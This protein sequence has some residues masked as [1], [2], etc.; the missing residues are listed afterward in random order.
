[1]ANKLSPFQS[2]LAGR[3]ARQADDYSTSRNMLASMEVA[4]APAEQERRNALANVQLNTA[5]LNNQGAQQSLD[6]DKA[7][8]AYAQ[9]RQARDSGNTKE[10]IVKQ[11]PE[12]ANQ[13]AR[14]NVDLNSMDESQVDDLVDQLSRK[15]GGEAGI[16]PPEAIT[17][18]NIGGANVLTQGGKYLNSF[19]NKA[20]S[21][22]GFTLPPGA[23]RFDANGKL[24]A[25]APDR[26]Q[27]SAAEFTTMTPEE[28]RAAGLPA[29]TSAQKN[30][31][32]GQVNVISK[33]E[34][35]AAE[36]K[37]QREIKAKIPR[38]KAADR[39]LA[40]VEQAVESIAKNKM[41]DGGEID[42]YAIDRTAEGRELIAASAQLLPELTA[43]T[44]VPGIGSQSDLE[45]RLANLQFPSSEFPPEV[46]RKNAAEL[47][48][49][50]SD[51]KDAYS[52]G[53]NEVTKEAPVSSP[54]ASSGP[55]RVRSIQEAQS[56]PPGTE[57]ITPDGRHKVR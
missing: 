29:G 33:P 48:A 26:P 45:T 1:M 5:Q 23:Q 35:N 43:L 50:I 3:E 24:I 56:L 27:K 47:R 18:Q 11:I 51:L 19:S 16:L 55:V 46:N 42:K 7:K 6:A 17:S 28:V 57:F 53:A 21:S 13:L 4:N 37:F 9:L 39:R 12:L 38:L 20:P 36:Q 10:F 49:F 41:F 8:F 52:S 40:R 25:T 30:L 2:F 44:R 31:T 14:N 32:T 34:S 15:Y 22:E 54:P